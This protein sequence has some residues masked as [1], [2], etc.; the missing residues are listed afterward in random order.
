M[1]ML[2]CLNEIRKDFNFYLFVL[3]VNHGVRGRDADEDEDLVYAWSKAQS[4]KFFSEKLKGLDLKSSE[5]TLRN[6][7]YAVFE[8]FLKAET[9]SKIATAHTLD[10]QLETFIMRLAKGSKLQGLCGIPVKRDA[11]IRPMLH[12]TKKEIYRFADDKKIPYKEDF[13]NRDPGKTR[14]RVRHEIVPKLIEVFGSRFYE[15]FDRSRNNLNEIRASFDAY[16]NNL[17]NTYVNKKGEILE[18]KLDDYRKLSVAERRYL[19]NGC[20]SE[21]YPLNFQIRSKYFEEFERFVD[22]AG[23]GKEFNFDNNLKVLKN[24]TSVKFVKDK[25]HTPGNPEL[26]P[27]QVVYIGRNKISMN[28]VENVEKYINQD[29]NTELICGDDLVFPLKVRFWKNGDFFFPLGMNKKQKLSDFF[30]NE[31]VNRLEKS[32]IPL[33]LNGPE[34]VWVAGLRLDDRY[35]VTESCRTVYQLTIHGYN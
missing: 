8:K 12:L 16:M 24:R 33:V 22:T 10:D 31:K 1:V 17:F 23:T 9:G 14:N 29:R 25:T 19:V 18:L 13:T 6:E 21:F 11:Y 20:V 35:K 30:I 32:Q 3:H 15:G 27:G 7:R 2:Y 5:D 34:M 4:L 26:Y 28:K